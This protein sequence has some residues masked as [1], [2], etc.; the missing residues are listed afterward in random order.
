MEVEVAFLFHPPAAQPAAEK[1]IRR[2]PA[3]HS[4]FPSR[5]LAM[6]LW[7]LA[8]LLACATAVLAGCPVITP[9]ADFNLTECVFAFNRTVE[10][11]SK[12][13]IDFVHG[14]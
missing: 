14:V 11:S 2:L 10:C 3:S 4:S 12:N 9:K 7:S 13:C 5:S 8:V 6:S 1:A